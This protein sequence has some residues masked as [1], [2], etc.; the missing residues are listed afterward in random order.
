MELSKEKRGHFLY[1]LFWPTWVFFN[2]CVL[3]QCIVYS[4]HF[5]N[6]F[7]HIKKHCFMHFCCLFLKSSKSFSVSL[8]IVENN[9]LSLWSIFYLMS[10][11]YWQLSRHGSGKRKFGYY[12]ITKWV[13]LITKRVVSQPKRILPRLELFWK[14]DSSRGAFLWNLRNF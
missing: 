11:L 1:S 9:A 10:V 3:S 7:L 14:K 4:I 2:I 13:I 12:K 6:I 8:I 5:Q